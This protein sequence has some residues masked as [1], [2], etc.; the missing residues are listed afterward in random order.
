MFHCLLRLKYALLDENINETR[1]FQLQVDLAKTRWIRCLDEFFR[2]MVFLSWPTVFEKCVFCQNF[3][4]QDFSRCHIFCC[5]LMDLILKSKW[6]KI[7]WQYQ[8]VFN[9]TILPHIFRIFDTNIKP[10]IFL[11]ALYSSYSVGLNHVFW[12]WWLHV[13]LHT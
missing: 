6:Y 12:V 13:P 9:N 11:H 1:I 4:H 3:E 2:S 8:G 7:G 10:N 5:L